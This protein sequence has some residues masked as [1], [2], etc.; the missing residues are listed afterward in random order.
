MSRVNASSLSTV[1]G[2]TVMRSSTPVSR[3]RHSGEPSSPGRWLIGMRTMR[4]PKCSLLSGS[5]PK[6][7]A[8]LRG[9]I[10]LRSVPNHTG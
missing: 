9:S 2:S 5:A 1:A 3:R 4:L 7:S 8:G 6:P 10:G